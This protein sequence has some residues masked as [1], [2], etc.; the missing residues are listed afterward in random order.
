MSVQGAQLL[1]LPIVI[2]Q[3]GTKYFGLLTT[4]LAMNAASS[5]VGMG[6]SK[7]MINEIARL[8]S[9]NRGYK[10]Y[11][12]NNFK[13]FLYISAILVSV[14]LVLATIYFY[15]IDETL[16]SQKE[17]IFVF[18][19]SFGLIILNSF[20]V[21][22]YRGLQQQ[23][24]IAKYQL[25]S[26][27]VSIFLV[28]ISLIMKVE[29]LYYAIFSMFVPPLLSIILGSRN[30]IF[31]SIIDLE[32]GV[33]FGYIKYNTTTFG[34]FCLGIIQFLSFNLDSLIIVNLLSFD[35]VAAYNLVNKFN[36]LSISIFSAFSASLWPVLSRLKYDQHGARKI[37]LLFIRGV[38]LTIIYIAGSFFV[39]AFILKLVLFHFMGVELDISNNFFISFAVQNALIIITSFLIPIF[40][41]YGIIKCQIIFGGLSTLVN[42]SLSFI[43][44]PKYGAIGSI[45]ATCLAHFSLCVIPYVYIFIKRV[46]RN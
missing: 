24:V 4:L 26:G 45:W 30:T 16:D 2:D 13:L 28:S 39:L 14:M 15:H 40:N 3:Y 27:W 5:L 9:E 23:A 36:L 33:N 43:F 37:K 34:F 22:L 41:A 12:W 46:W 21:D 19:L 32:Y 20:M 44:I 6:I 7:Q 10:K 1:I 35:S 29:V 18:I 31:R 8:I 25:Y 17:L 38:S 42:L 11:A